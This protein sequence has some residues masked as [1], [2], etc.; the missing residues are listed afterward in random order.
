MENKMATI[1]LPRIGRME[2]DM[3][4]IVVSGVI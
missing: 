2:N 1:L 4:T 3:E